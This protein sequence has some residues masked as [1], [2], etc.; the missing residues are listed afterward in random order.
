MQYRLTSC[1]SKAEDQLGAEG[2]NE[3]YVFYYPD[4]H[5]SLESVET[6]FLQ[7]SQT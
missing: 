6:G 5:G 2:T 4:S 3:M 1:L 7:A